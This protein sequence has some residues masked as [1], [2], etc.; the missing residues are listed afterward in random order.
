MGFASLQHT[1]ERRSTWREVAGLATFRPQGLATLSAVY[2]LRARAGLISYRRRSWDFALRSFLHPEG[3][4]RVSAGKDPRTVSPVGFSRRCCAGPA[5][6]AAVS[7]LSPFRESLATATGLVR[8]A[9]AAPLGFT[10]LGL[11][12]AASHGISPA[13]LPRALQKPISRPELPAPRSIEQPLPC[14]ARV[15]ENRPPGKATLTGFPHRTT[16]ASV[17]A[18]RRPGYWVHLASRRASLPTADA[19][20]TV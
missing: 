15:P 18:I 10:L 20:W 2:S 9:L 3:I 17:R 16:P 8:Q 12:A 6:R 5:Q 19:L 7:G 4:R 13:L 11:S 1:R 14:P